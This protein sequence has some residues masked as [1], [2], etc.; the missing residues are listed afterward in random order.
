MFGFEQSIWNLSQHVIFPIRHN[1]NWFP[2]KKIYKL[3]KVVEKQ[4]TPQLLLPF[5]IKYIYL[6]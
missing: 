5:S 6:T 4:R 1:E 3:L 2:Y